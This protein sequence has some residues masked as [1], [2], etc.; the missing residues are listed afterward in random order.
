MVAIDLETGKVAWDDKLPSAPFG[1]A[2]FS[3]GIVYTTM[4]AGEVVAFDAKT[5][6]EHLEGQAP[7]QGQLADRDHR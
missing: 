1:D 2:T 7:G 6:K 4:F 3:N 5:G